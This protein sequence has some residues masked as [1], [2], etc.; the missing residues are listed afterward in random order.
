MD[1][2][3]F[4]LT[5][6]SLQRLWSRQFLPWHNQADYEEYTVHQCKHSGSHSD[7]F[8]RR[9]HQFATISWLPHFCH[10]DLHDSCSNQHQC[11]NKVHHVF[12]CCC[13]WDDHGR[14]GVEKIG[15]KND[16]QEGD[17]GKMGAQKIYFTNQEHLMPVASWSRAAWWKGSSAV[18]GKRS[19]SDDQRPFF[20]SP[21]GY[22]TW[23]GKKSNVKPPYLNHI[24][25]YNTR[26]PT[27]RNTVSEKAIP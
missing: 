8:L 21:G 15:N 20:H 6:S 11:Q 2:P 18:A 27:N 14:C 23:N 16:N 9:I 26:R 1:T 13:F 4:V 17:D 12:Q 24:L 22:Q 19:G 25:I 7:A 5:T 3:W 10:G